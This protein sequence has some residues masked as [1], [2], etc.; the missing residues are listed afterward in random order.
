MLKNAEFCARFA[1]A[2][3]LIHPASLSGLK[4]AGPVRRRGP[5][6]VFSLYR[7]PP[8]FSGLERH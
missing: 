7:K 5:T 4:Q 3:A 2:H 1:G 8:R 6:G